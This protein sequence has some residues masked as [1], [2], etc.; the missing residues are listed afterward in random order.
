[1]VTDKE[2][3]IE[4]SW[5]EC[6]VATKGKRNVKYKGFTG[7][8]QAE[9]YI[10]RHKNK[11]VSVTP[12][13]G[14]ESNKTATLKTSSPTKEQAEAQINQEQSPVSAEDITQ[15][16]DQHE[17]I[18][19]AIDDSKVQRKYCLENCKYENGDESYDTMLTC[20]I[21][22]SWY[23]LTCINLTQETAQELSACI[24]H[25]CKAN[26]GSVDFL[27]DSVLQSIGAIQELR[28]ELAILK[29][30]F[31]QSSV[32]EGNK[33]GDEF[34]GSEQSKL[35][36]ND[37]LEPVPYYATSPQTRLPS[38]HL[39]TQ[40]STQDRLSYL[41]GKVESINEMFKFLMEE[42]RRND[43]LFTGV[44]AKRQCQCDNDFEKKSLQEENNQ[45]QKRVT[46]FERI[47]I[48]GDSKAKPN[49]SRQKDKR[50]QVSV[51]DEEVTEQFRQTPT[52]RE[53]NA[54]YC[55]VET[56]NHQPNARLKAKN[57]GK[58]H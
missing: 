24:C 17:E 18:L 15:T 55:D 21:C 26:I 10:K 39:K 2:T 57:M 44:I 22:D 58:Q 48:S 25:Q 1:M 20:D 53:E 36:F 38:Q 31:I 52:Q 7:K 33:N 50:F 47:I 54:N 29:N 27:K 43:S 3:N 11:R 40:D 16:S 42:E 56:L 45:L 49:I 12:E 13:K 35:S 14:K 51:D 8:E 19:K 32:A 46:E 34:H 37:A 9:A 6:Q 41:E 5:E 4:T 30:K 23:H 28:H